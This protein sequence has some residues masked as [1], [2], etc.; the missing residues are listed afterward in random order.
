M[1]NQQPNK[2]SLKQNDLIL[3]S[4]DNGSVNYTE[5]V[6]DHCKLTYTI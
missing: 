2:L 4:G 1:V 5:A 6:A 3:L